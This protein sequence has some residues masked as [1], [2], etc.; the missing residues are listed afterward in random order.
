MLPRVEASLPGIRSFSERGCVQRGNGRVEV[1]VGGNLIASYTERDRAT[2]NATLIGLA[3]DPSV[4][5][6]ELA[7]AFDVS[8]ETL[9]LLRKQHAA[10]GIEGVMRRSPGGSESIV[11]PSRRR[12]IDGLFDEGLTA[13]RVGRFDRAPRAPRAQAPNQ[14]KNS[15]SRA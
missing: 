5:L 2:R 9:R 7:D 11:S 3:A 15:I 10:E 13:R 1:F 8:L 6:G 12:R 4:H 14:L